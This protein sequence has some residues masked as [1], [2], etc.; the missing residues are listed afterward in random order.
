MQRLDPRTAANRENAKKSTG[1]R[2][3]EGKERSRANAFQHGLSGSGVAWPGE[4]QAAMDAF[5]ARW[6]DSECPQDER[7]LF[8]V[9]RSATL[10]WQIDRGERIEAARASVA[11]E[12]G[13]DALESRRKDDVAQAIEGL[14]DDPLRSV[15]RL[16]R[17]LGG[18]DWILAALG[19][20]AGLIREGK[21]TPGCVDRLD[22][23]CGHTQPGMLRPSKVRM[24]GQAWDPPKG[25]NPA[26]PVAGELLA[27][28]EARMAE[29]QGQ[30]DQLAGRPD[31]EREHAAT[32][33]AFDESPQGERIRRYLRSLMRE[34]RSILRELEQ[35]RRDRVSRMEP[36]A[37]PM[38]APVP[39][40]AAPR[41]ERPGPAP[42]TSPNDRGQLIPE[43]EVM[44]NRLRFET[45]DF[46]IGRT[47]REPAMA[48]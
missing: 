2:T 16:S 34:R 12:G 22:A 48:R 31:P 39:A 29:V 43:S 11:A 36:E 19:E 4:D 42:R 38:P 41:A 13:V 26:D 47:P 25:G 15:R 35:L 6:V 5:V 10:A 3:E 33:A 1:P 37:A 20:L 40:P 28:I 8:L 21:W 7:E 18:C 46:A 9:T 24:L 17:S 32:L 30:R 45:I 27:R 23:L 44:S 14:G